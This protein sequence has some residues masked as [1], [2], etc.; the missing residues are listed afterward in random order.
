MHP[1]LLASRLSSWLPLGRRGFPGISARVSSTALVVAGALLSILSSPVEYGAAAAFDVLFYRI[2][3]DVHDPAAYLRKTSVPATWAQYTGQHAFVAGGPLSQ[4]ITSAEF[5]KWF[6][7][8]DVLKLYLRHPSEAWHVTEVN[9][10]KASLDRVR[11]KTGAVQHRL[12]NYERTLGKKPQAL[13]YFLCPLPLLKAA[14][15]ADRPNIYLAYV[16]F[17]LG[18]FGILIRRV[19]RARVLLSLIC[20][21]LALQWRVCLLDGVASGRHLLL[22]NFVLDVVSC[23]NLGIATAFLLSRYTGE[24]STK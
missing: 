2:L 5:S 8:V 18:L 6:G 21:F 15:V 13:S 10:D 3:P 11:M 7:P 20:V 14:L 4:P 17:N 9:L 1:R 22:F 12:G 19:P 24:I 16:L 23:L